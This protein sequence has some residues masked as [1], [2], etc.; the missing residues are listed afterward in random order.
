[1][2]SHFI[3]FKA[4]ILQNGTIDAAYVE[5]P[6]S[7]EEYFGKK[8]SVKIKALFDDHIEYRGSLMKMKGNCHLLG[9]TRQIRKQLG[10]SFGDEV[11]VKLCEDTEERIVAIPDDIQIIFN[12]NLKAKEIFEGMSYTHRKEYIRWILEA[13]KTETREKRKVKM[14][15]MILAGKK[16]I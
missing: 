2:K 9:L 4:V 16:G 8:R 15:E 13:K 10:K 5:F 3:S 14:I 11:L 7:A 12:E 1:M 6:F